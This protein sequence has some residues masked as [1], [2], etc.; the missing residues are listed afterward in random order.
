MRRKGTLI[1]SKGRSGSNWL[2]SLT[3]A[4]GVLGHSDEWIDARESGVVPGSVDF[5]TYLD[6][7]VRIASTPNGYFCFKI[8]PRHLFTVQEVYGRDL[9][10]ELRGAFDTQVVV[11]KRRDRIAQAISFAKA[12]ESAQWKVDRVKKKTPVYD[13]DMVCRC[14]FHIDR[15]Y[16]F[17]DSYLALKGLKVQEFYY[18]DLLPDPSPFIDC[19]A[20]HAGVA[21]YP[22]TQSDMPIQRNADSDRW[23]VQFLKDLES[24][25]VLPEA[26]PRLPV[27]TGSNLVNFLRRRPMKP[28]PFVW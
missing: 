17:W 16:A 1:L 7:I 22:V 27:V 20:R 11:L 26:N 13:F 14:Y 8:F 23:R 6:R 28:K 24:R 12:Y 15:A 9:I 19:I 25:N 4:T 2:G 5:E 21:E 3:N 18:E 10:E